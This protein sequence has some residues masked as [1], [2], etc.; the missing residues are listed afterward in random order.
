MVLENGSNAMIHKPADEAGLLAL[1]QHGVKQDG[2]VHEHSALEQGRDGK[3]RAGAACACP[4]PGGASIVAGRAHHCVG[5]PPIGMVVIPGYFAFHTRG[6]SSS[7]FTG[8]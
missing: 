6:N 7:C 5:D 2:Q 1:E 4:P 3:E 8:M